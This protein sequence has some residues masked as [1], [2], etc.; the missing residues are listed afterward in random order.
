VAK[1]DIK[2]EHLHRPSDSPEPSNDLG[3]EHV[4]DVVIQVTQAYCPNGH[5]LIRNRD[6]LFDGCPGISLWIS[7]GQTEG[8]VLISPY[9]GDPSRKGQPSFK[10]GQSISIACPECKAKLP[11]LSTCACKNGASLLAVFLTKSLDEGQV[12]GLCDVW[13]CHRSKIFDQAQLL[14]AY[15]ES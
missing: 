7:D 3:I 11:R 5:S 9:H 8:E 10:E 1:K 12:I 13:G 6:E 14:A 15:M 2:K 4:D